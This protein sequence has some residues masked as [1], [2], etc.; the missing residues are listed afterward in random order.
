MNPHPPFRLS[1][2]RPCLLLALLLLMALAAPARAVD[3][4]EDVLRPPRQ[5]NDLLSPYERFW[6]GEHPELRIAV[7]SHWPPFEFVDETGRYRGMVADYLELIQQ[8]LGYRFTLV[9]VNSWREALDAL[10]RREVD[11][12]PAVALSPSREGQML[13]SESYYSFPIVLA[14]RDDMPFIGGLDELDQER[15][16]V[17]RD[18]S[19]QDFLLISHP[20]LNLAFVDSLE[21]GLLKVSSGELDVLVSNIPSLSYLINRLGIGNI[22]ITG[23]TP[24]T[25]EVHFGIRQDMP[26]LRSIVDKALATIT[27][28]EHDAIYKR[29]I[30]RNTVADTDYSLVWRVVA[31]AAV[32]VVIFLYWNRKLSR[33]ITERMRSEEALRQSEEKLRAAMEEAERLASAAEAANKAKS[34]FLANMSHEIRTPMNAVLGYTELLEVLVTDEK[35][36]S[37]LESIKKG[38]RALL[39][40]INDILDLSRIESGK[41]KMEYGPVSPQ[42]LLRDVEQIFSARAAQKKLEFRISIAEDLPP[43]LVLDEVRLRQ[44]LFNL[45]GNAIKFTHEGHIALSARTMPPRQN[46]PD[47]VDLILSVEDT[48]IGIPKDQQA[49]IFNAFEQQEGQSNRIYGG[50]GLGL[51]ISKKLVEMMNGEIRLR[52]EP[53]KGSRFDVHLFDVAFGK[54]Q[55]AA[56]TA[57]A[58]RNYRF[59]PAK[60]LVVDDVEMNRNL[61]RDNFSNSPFEILEADDGQRAVALALEHQPQ[62]ILMD[63]RMP[64]L[65]GFAALERLRA[66]PETRAIPVIALTASI[67]PSQFDRIEQAGFDAYLRKPISRNDLLATVARFLPQEAPKKK[68]ETKAAPATKSPA[69][70][71]PAAVPAIQDWPLLQEQLRGPLQAEWEEL[72][73]SGDMARMAAFANRLSELAER[74][75]APELA[76]YGLTLS[77]QVGQFDLAGLQETLGSFPALV[78]SLTA[79]PQAAPKER[80]D[81][82]EDQQ[83]EISGATFT[84]SDSSSPS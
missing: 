46:A 25:D 5:A 53:G 52:S 83:R 54:Q 76:Q 45:V 68:A 62:L 60:L 56:I 30:S 24:Y 12:L 1:M 67:Q 77:Q 51:A 47:R 55:D 35:Q 3:T 33:E 74:A 59:K 38:G 71:A 75:G 11:A 8:R 13:F 64:V 6:L 16:G 63:L 15:V 57:P 84:S 40:I 66:Q 41:M 39:T 21:E 73:D 34:E 26:E 7:H 4:T 23:I 9:P 22:K 65:D 28:E 32:V 29:W 37:Y 17:V 81:P 19:S 70:K 58:K 27:E 42:R 44:V 18:Y 61:I 69:P 72:K 82:A 31:V 49:R 50:T 79:H 2:I 36:K 80:P 48:G 10:K 20:Q 78:E 43:A 14:V